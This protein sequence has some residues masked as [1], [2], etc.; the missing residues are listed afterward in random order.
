MQKRRE[1]LKTCL[2]GGAVAAAWP[3]RTLEG[4]VNTLLPIVE[5]PSG[6]ASVPEILARIKPPVFPDHDFDVTKFGARGDNKTECTEAIRQA[7][8]ACHAAGGGRVVLP[9]GEFLTGAIH[10]KSNVN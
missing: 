4:A 7:I 5:E 3:A 9:A 1:F 2:L 8:A 6:W 10:L